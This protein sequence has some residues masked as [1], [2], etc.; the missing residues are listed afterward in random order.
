MGYSCTSLCLNMPVAFVF[1]LVS[2][3]CVQYT[4]HRK[5]QQY[6]QTFKTFTIKKILFK[7]IDIIN[8]FN[9]DSRKVND[10]DGRKVDRDSRKVDGEMVVN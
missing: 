3:S 5:R 7:N 10:R 2:I 1:H 8:C 9:I 6:Q 4:T